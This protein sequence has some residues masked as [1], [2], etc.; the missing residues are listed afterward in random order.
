MKLLLI[1]D[2]VGKPGRA[3]L[4]DRLQDLKEQHE[5]D[6]TVMN[7]ENVAGGFSIT[8]AIAD[9]LFSSGIDVMTS[10]NHIFDKYE[11]IEYIKKQPRLLRPA[12]YPPHTPGNGM[13]TGEVKGAGVA[14]ISLLGRVFMH[15]A[16]DPF[17]VANELLASLGNDIRIRLV[18]MHAEAT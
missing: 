16:D 12:N 11:V 7:A 2:V 5:I 1:G 17:R 8:A 15:P 6:F 9:L 18:D 4:L 10:G 3:A 13:W 14:V